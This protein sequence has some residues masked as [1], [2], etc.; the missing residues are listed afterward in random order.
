MQ[1]KTC[2]ECGAEY[3][4]KVPYQKYC[5]TK[6]ARVARVRRWRW[7]SKHGCRDLAAEA[8][9]CGHLVPNATIMRAR[10]K[11]KGVSDIRWHMELRRR[12]NPQHYALAEGV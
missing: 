11:P 8:Y 12:A 1:Q 5:S 9:Q 4:P 2:A 3:A 7:R 10:R 6:C